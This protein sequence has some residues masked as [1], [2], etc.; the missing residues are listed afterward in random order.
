MADGSEKMAKELLKG[1][2]IA[3]PDGTPAK[4]CA[5]IKFNSH[6]GYHDLCKVNKNLF[7]THKH[8]IFWKGDWVFPKSIKS[9]R[10]VACDAVYNLITE[11]VHIAIVNG[12]PAIL[13]GHSYQEGILKHPYLGSQ[14][15]R[16]D[17]AAMPGWDEG[18]IELEPG[19]F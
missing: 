18:W 10:T 19:C 13:M 8:P 11:N 1:D 9:Q 4:I 12:V 16:D 17:F 6:N 5:V 3:T 15:I 14:E 7:I 2:L